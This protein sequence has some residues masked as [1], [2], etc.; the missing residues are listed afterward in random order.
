MAV[1][2]VGAL[3]DTIVT[4]PLLAALRAHWPAAALIAIGRSDAFALAGEWCDRVHSSESVGWW[5]ASSPGVAADPRLRA[6]LAGVDVVLDFDGDVPPARA[7]DLG[8]GEWLRFDALPPPGFGRAAARHYLDAA[9]FLDAPEFVESRGARSE[10]AARSGPLA[11][12]PGAGSPRK[13]A[14]MEWFAERARAARRA[15]LGVAV[16]VG[17]ADGAAASEARAALPWTE[18]WEGLPLDELAGRLR[19][20]S[21]FASNDSGV[22]H[23]A[24]LVGLPGTV[25]FVAGDPAVWAPP[26]PRVAVERG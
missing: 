24:A 16:V 15:G 23:L 25:R 22:A 11:L 8:V 4:F 19:A 1:A 9:G 12:A 17:E 26:S 13:R 10:E 18:W 21:S 6:A 3:G 5:T 20:C 14:P 7:R 2:R